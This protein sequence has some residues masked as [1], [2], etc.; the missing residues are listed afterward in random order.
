[1]SA[2]RIS[3]IIAIR[4]IDQ[5]DLG[6]A[7]EFLDAMEQVLQRHWQGEENG[8][9]QAMAAREAQYADYVAP[10]VVEHR[11]LAELLATVDISDPADQQRLRVAFELLAEQISKE[12]DG[13]FPAAVSLWVVPSGTH[14][15]RLGPRHIRARR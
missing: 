15:W 9:F 4:A 5:G 13:L 11:E 7:E 2:P 10:L 1:M 3:A 8:I 14:R 6:A 12:E